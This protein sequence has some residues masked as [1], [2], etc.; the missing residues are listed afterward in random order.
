VFKLDGNGVLTRIAGNTGEGF[1]GDGGPA[2]NATFRLSNFDDE[3]GLPG[4]AVDDGGGVYIADSGNNRIRLISA[5]GTITTIAGNSD[6]GNSGDGG[7]ARNAQLAHPSSLVNYASNLS[8]YIG[9]GDSIRRLTPGGTLTTIAAVTPGSAMATDSADN[10]YIAGGGSVRKLAPGGEITTIAAEDGAAIAVDR[11]GNVFLAEAA[12]IREITPAG[13]ITTIAGNGICGF[14][15]DGGPATG[16]Q[17]CANGLAV[18]ANGNLYLAEAQSRRVR[19]ISPNGIIST[20]AGNG[21]CCYS[22]DSGPAINAEFKLAPWGGG[23]AVDRGGSLYIADAANQ[24]IRK[25]SPTGVITTVAGNGVSNGYSGDEGSAID[26]QLNYPSEVVVDSRGN[27]YIADVGNQRVRKVSADGIITTVV[28]AFGR[29]LAVDSA[30]ALY[31]ADGGGVHRI[32][33]TGMLTTLT[34]TPLNVPF[35]A[36]V[37]SAGNYFA[38]EIGSQIYRVRKVSPDGVI[39]TVAGGDGTAGYSGDGGP[40]ANAQLNGPAALAID[41]NDNVYIA[42]SFNGRIWM[43]SASG[44][45]T[46]VAGSGAPGYSGDGGFATSAQF[47]SL[48]GLATDGRGNVYAADQYYNALR[49]LQPAS[50]KPV[51]GAISNAASNVFGAIAPGEL[52]VLTGL[53]LGP[54]K[55]VSAT[56]GADGL[57]PVHLAE[58]AVLVNGIP[59]SL[60]YTSA[61][62]VAAVVPASAGLG[63][64]VVLVTF[65]G[66]TSFGIPIPVA[67][68]S[69]GLFTVDFTGRSDAVTINQNGLID[70]PVDWGDAI[71]LFV[72]G[73]GL[74]TAG[75]VIFYP[76]SPLQTVV[77][78]S[79][80]SMQ[81][82]AAGVTGIRLPIPSGREAPGGAFFKSTDGGSGASHLR[83]RPR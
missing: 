81:T 30:D 25:V 11:S 41:S 71:T 68:S 24:R 39:T 9:S 5:D 34:T 13:L 76:D 3:P 16:A 66:Q 78:V 2:V 49:L 18:D 1:S 4:I 59:A 70:E 44:I 77:P 19:K 20:V 63:A 65:Q 15:G 32:D 38:A 47:G 46:T 28:E 8:I 27:I 55:L 60:V 53:G 21:E 33:P 80:D 35:A 64:A 45:I 17:V 37:D 42:D 51:I 6:S 52:V 74:A 62:Q 43:V 54:S 26:A 23:L 36:A 48:S 29:A 57:Y 82:N 61:T 10:L 58:T 69:P 14:S 7:L 40:A 72:T 83:R 31:F 73:T 67:G 22:G 56:P 79:G 12:R 50:P 75:S